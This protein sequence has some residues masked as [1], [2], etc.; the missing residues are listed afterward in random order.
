MGNFRNGKLKATVYYS[1][2]ETACQIIEN[3]GLWELHTLNHG[4]TRLIERGATILAGLAGFQKRRRAI[5]IRDS[6]SKACS[7]PEIH[8]IRYICGA[9]W[10]GVFQVSTGNLLS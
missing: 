3:D 10:K 4:R 5:N 6:N 1:N 8:T 2:R 9:E 7:N